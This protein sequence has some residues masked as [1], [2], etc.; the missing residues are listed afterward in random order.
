MINIDNK[1]KLNYHK[2]NIT[3]INEIQEYF[4]CRLS[5]I[6]NIYCIEM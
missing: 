4:K 5:Q 1:Y 2:L 3:G 6:M